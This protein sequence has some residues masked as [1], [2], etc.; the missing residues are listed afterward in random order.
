M[1][2]T[3][4]RLFGRPVV[5]HAGAALPLA[6]ERRNRLLVLLALRRG[7]VSRAELA[8]AFWPDHA[9]K[10]ALANVRKAMHLAHELPWAAALETQGSTVRFNV[11]TDV[12][13]FERALQDG[14]VTDAVQGRGGELLD[15]WDDPS[16]AA[17]TEWLDGQRAQHGRLWQRATRARLV[18]LQGAWPDAAAFARGLI[19]A[20]PLDE[21]AMVALLAAQRALG[22]LD[23][24]RETYRSFAD[25]LHDE[26]GVEPSARVREQLHERASLPAPPSSDKQAALPA[27]ADGFVGRERE[28]EELQAM[29]ARPECRL[30]TI[31]GPGGIGK[32]SLAKQALRRLPARAGTER[33]LWIALDDL[34][35]IAQVVS[36]IAVELKVVPG[37]AQ[38]PLL[39]VCHELKAPNA[40]LARLVFDNSEHLDGLPRLAERLLAEAPA[41]KIIAT[42]RV[43]LGLK[44]EWL[45]PL[46]GLAADDAGRL[47]IAAAGAVK[48]GFDAARQAPAIARVVQAVGGLPLALLL[49]AQWCRLWPVAEIAAEIERSLDVLDNGDEGEE[50]PEHRSVRATFEQSWRLLGA[51]EQ[52]A[53]AALT[54]FVGGFA[55]DAALDVAGATWPLLAALADKSLLQVD[56]SR[57]S[58]HPLVRQFA[59]EKLGEPA[60]AIAR[61]R[62]GE[63]FHRLLARSAAAVELGER[64]ALDEIEL[65]LEN[66]RQAWRWAVAASAHAALAASALPLM[67]FFELRGRTVE[68]A[69]LLDEARACAGGDAAASAAEASV[70]AAVAQLLFRMYHLDEAAERARRAL[71]LARTAGPSAALLLSLQVLANCLFARGNSVEAKRIFEQ[72][73]RRAQATGNLLAAATAVGNLAMVEA[74]LGNA[75]RSRDLMLDVLAQHRELGNWHRIPTLLN[76]LAALHISRGEWAEARTCAL[77][78]LAASERH[79]IAQVRPHLLLNL[80]SALFNLGD[81]DESDRVI[82]QGLDDARTMANRAAETT[83]L[84]H[85]LR[86]AL[87]K[88]R[89]TDARQRLREA[90]VSSAEMQGTSVRL[91]ILFSFAKILAAEGHARRAAELLRYFAARDDV[92]PIERSEALALLDSVG[93]EATDAP[94]PAAT[95]DALVES[96]KSELHPAEVTD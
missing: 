1:P 45:L 21:D 62:H 63:R 39:A 67:R 28:L 15:G 6:A 31:V 38:D 70:A 2:T 7:W 52:A 66:C 36:R 37:P 18:E 60:L 3:R 59:A 58:L 26:L 96:I 48:P 23:E 94:A 13:E 32:S 75:E 42:S 90:I 50:R 61:R 65:E 24:Q 57:C 5:E 41:L 43:R 35:N 17:W 83:A 73:L 22:R 29:L 87:A 4:L 44:G 16:N 30:L 9:A 51:R 92:E 11:A 56:G 81:I 71:R 64:A 12:H 47:F 91:D 80:A 93:P 33:S 49:A 54:V 46:K 10:L 76:N 84:I 95:L 68:G 89:C 72:A 19:E 20:D 34:G 74:R 86:I 40:R 14:R 78:G 88:G 27:A 82:R 55:R 77:E 25:R 85:L 69:A 53:L 8:A 79:G